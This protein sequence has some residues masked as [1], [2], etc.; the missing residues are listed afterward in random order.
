MN[1]TRLKQMSSILV[2][3]F[4][5]PDID[6]YASAYAYAEL[7]QKLGVNAEAAISG[8]PDTE[9][10]HILK[11]YKIKELPSAKKA[12]DKAE[13]IILVDASDITGIDETIKPAKVVEI[14]DHRTHNDIHLFKKADVTI[15]I[16]GATSTLIAELFI[17]LNI[18]L[19]DEAATLLYAGIISDTINFKSK[20][21]TNRD[22]R[23]AAF[24]LTKVKFPED[25]IEKMFKAKSNFKEQTV[26]EVVEK[27]LATYK[28]KRNQVGIA[29]ISIVESVKFVQKNIEDLHKAT[30]RLKKKY[31][32]DHM[33]VKL[34]DLNEGRNIFIT[35]DIETQKV[36]IKNF[37]VEFEEHTAHSHGIITRKEMAPVLKHH[38]EGTDFDI[39]KIRP[40]DFNHFSRHHDDEED[41]GEPISEMI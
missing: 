25:F 13:S 8:D 21:T 4:R 1:L 3:P 14:V 10:D 9:T 37:Q 34:I 20:L 29:Q 6:G 31:E 5:N 11:K 7:L 2:T 36:L 38:F 41:M 22:K 26:Y 12:I 19:S 24:L 27:S 33:F 28:F 15:E 23:T 40:H 18:P 30:R 35:E 39:N 17:E 32:L 16:I